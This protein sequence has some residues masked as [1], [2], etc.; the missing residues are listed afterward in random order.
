MVMMAA[1]ALVMPM[2]ARAGSAAAGQ[3]Q[4]VIGAGSV[5]NLNF[6]IANTTVTYNLPGWTTNNAL[7]STNQLPAPVF[8]AVGANQLAIV[9]SQNQTATNTTTET[10]N[11]VCSLDNATWIVPPAPLPISISVATLNTNYSSAPLIWGT[12]FNTGGFPLWAIAST[13][14]SGTTGA[15]TNDVMKAYTKTGGI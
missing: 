8:F 11:L 15:R 2:T 6:V 13:T 14:H 9:D 1:M 10:Y 12:N 7:Y 4:S 3:L 5:S